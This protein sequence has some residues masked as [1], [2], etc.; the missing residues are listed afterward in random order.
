[1]TLI[2]PPTRRRRRVDL[3]HSDIPSKAN[4][5]LYFI[6]IAI[7]LILVRIWHL[8]IIQYDQKLD[9]FQKPRLK[10]SIV[11]A[12]RATIRD[13]FNLPLAINKMAYQ[14]AILYSP[15]RDIPS[16]KWEKEANGKRIKIFE[17]KNYIHKL[18][19]LLAAELQLDGEYVE[20][21][22][23]SKAS[24]YSQVPFVIKENISEKEYYRLKML[25][26]D[27]PA[28]HARHI[29][30]RDYPKKRVAAD[31]IGYMGAIDRSHYEKILHEM[32][33]LEAF[34]CASENEQEADPI[35]GIED[36]RQARRRLKDLE[37]KAYTLHDYVGKTGI[38]GT[39]E[40]ELR[41]FCGKKNYYTD[42]RGNFLRELPGSRPPLPGKRVLL[43]LSSQLQEY[44]EQLLAENEALRVVR[45]TSLVGAKQ[46]VLA[47]KEPW[48][49]GGA[50]VVMDPTTAEILALASYPRF[51]PNDFILSGDAE[52]RKRKKMGIH[53]WLESDV[54]IAALWNQQEPLKRERYDAKKRRF[55]DEA[56]FLTWGAYLDFILPSEGNLRRSV[57]K[58]KTLSQAIEIQREIEALRAL[59]SK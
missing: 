55:Y 44:A 40:E 51:D 32:K 58:V 16:F 28:L 27:W 6:L 3:Q 36:V 48:I 33:A 30:K 2:A 21:L 11:P 59:F 25:E 1:M 5:V 15:I 24:Y 46:T 23:H 56:K 20:D 12:P 37:A 41:G 19:N 14:A 17:R 10:S 31:V 45:K 7:L 52:E 39:Y 34:I 53:H 22:I 26:K 43:T 50:I 42:S 8:S 47:K 38:E 29:P 54:E 18:A 4:R 35:P 13:R 49:K 57:D 9:E